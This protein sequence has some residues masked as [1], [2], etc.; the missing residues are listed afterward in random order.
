MAVAAISHRAQACYTVTRVNPNYTGNPSVSQSGNTL[1]TSR[2]LH[3]RQK[4]LWCNGKLSAHDTKRLQRELCSKETCIGTFLPDRKNLLV[5]PAS[6]DEYKVRNTTR[7]VGASSHWVALLDSALATLRLKS[8]LL[9]T[10]SNL[11]RRHA[12]RSWTAQS[13]PRITCTH[14]ASLGSFLAVHA[15]SLDGSFYNVVGAGYPTSAL[16]MDPLA[17]EYLQLKTSAS[18]K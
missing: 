1:A 2:S 6:K 13:P 15:S 12:H 18:A 7:R 3:G 5:G 11:H 9:L 14:L 4:P 17:A 16:Q 10:P 8:K